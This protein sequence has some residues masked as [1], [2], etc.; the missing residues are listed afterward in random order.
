MLLETANGAACTAGAAG[1]A[2]LA[3]LAWLGTAR[4][5]FGEVTVASTGETT[6][7][8]VGNLVAIGAGA[9]ISLGGSLYAP[10]L[11]FRW[12]DLKRIPVVDEIGGEEGKIHR[13]DP[14]FGSTLTASNRDSQSNC[15]VNWE[16]MGQPCGFQ[17]RAARLQVGSAT[18]SCSARPRRRPTRRSAS[19]SSSSWRGPPSAD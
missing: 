18:R 14:D 2:A 9:A 17:V 6:P 3:L 13:V 4:L 1:G 15:L 19:P 12:A 16:I 5:L 7:L 11:K 8:L 10:D